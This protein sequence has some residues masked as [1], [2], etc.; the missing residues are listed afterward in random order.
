MAEA[1]GTDQ[2]WQVLSFYDF[3]KSNNLIDEVQN[4][5][6]NA[7]GQKYNGDGAVYGPK[8]KDQVTAP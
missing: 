4:N 3:C 6:W 5:Q 1:F 2:R 8:L 7:F